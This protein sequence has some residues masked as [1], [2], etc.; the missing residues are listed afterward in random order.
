MNTSESAKPHRATKSHSKF[1]RFL[2]PIQVSEILACSEQLVA[3]LLRQGDLAHIVVGLGT[4]H[5]RAVRIPEEALAEFIASRRN[6]K[7]KAKAA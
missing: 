7:A 5:R 2:T 1:P 3:K 6:A 4:R